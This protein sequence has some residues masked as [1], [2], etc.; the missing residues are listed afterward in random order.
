MTRPETLVAR[1]ALT[2]LKRSLTAM[3]TVLEPLPGFVQLTWSEAEVTG[4]GAANAEQRTLL[5]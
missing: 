1:R 4:P 5:G 3:T 2:E